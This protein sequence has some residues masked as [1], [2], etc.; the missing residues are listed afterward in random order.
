MTA[1]RLKRYPSPSG[2]LALGKMG[3]GATMLK[4]G[5][6]A[7]D[8]VQDG[9]VAMWDGIE[10]AGYGIHDTNATTWKNLIGDMA[11]DMTVPAV[12]DAEGSRISGVLSKKEQIRAYKRSASGM[13]EMVVVIIIIGMIVGFTGMYNTGTMSYIEKTRD[14]ATLKVLGFPTNK[15]RW[16]L[17]QQNL[18]LTGL[19]TIIGIP[20]G[21]WYI[22]LLIDSMDPTSDLIVDLSFVPYLKMV[23]FS[24]G[25]SMLV[26]ALI[27]ARVKSIDMV[28]ALKG[29]E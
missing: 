22:N 13:S 12:H 6:T 18:I 16:I 24:F 3:V 4:Q 27:S 7:R 11:W 20:N 10:N 2:G 15:I 5:K 8:Y 19:G 1:M 9:L 29:V 25:L 26:N 28:E 17:Q 23:L 14:V 21:L